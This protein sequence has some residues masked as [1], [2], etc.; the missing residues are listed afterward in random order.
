MAA[1]GSA[2]EQ[3]VISERGVCGGP[4]ALNSVDLVPHVAFRQL[5]AC[6]R[7]THQSHLGCQL[8]MPQQIQAASGTSVAK[9]NQASSLPAML[10]SSSALQI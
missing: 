8:P 4:L 6:A 10:L 7:P 1:L 5:L 3:L 2:A 9:V